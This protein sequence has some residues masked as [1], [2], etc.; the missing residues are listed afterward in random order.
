MEVQT[1]PVESMSGDL[2]FVSAGAV[3]AIDLGL[4]DALAV[5]LRRDAEGHRPIGRLLK[6]GSVSVVSHL[7]S[8]VFELLSEGAEFRPRFMARR[9]RHSVLSCECR[10]SARRAAIDQKNC[11]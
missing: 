1:G 10:K 2:G 6:D 4:V 9:A 7:V 8:V 5:P 3:R 11:E